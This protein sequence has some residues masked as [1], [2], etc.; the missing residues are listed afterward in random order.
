M[1]SSSPLHPGGSPATC[2]LWKLTNTTGGHNKF[3]TVAINLEKGFSYEVVAFW[4]AIGTTG[5][6]Q[7]KHS[8][9]GTL[10][11]ATT[12][13]RR[14]VDE[15]LSKGYKLISETDKEEAEMKEPEVVPTPEAPEKK[16]YEEKEI[17]LHIN[18]EETGE[19]NEEMKQYIP[20]KEYFLDT[21][22]L[23]AI[24]YGV[25]YNKPT[26]LIGDT[27]C[28]KTAAVR[29]LGNITNNAVRRVNLNGATTVD[30]FVGKW[31][32]DSGNMIW[33]DGVLTECMRKGY[34]LVCDE[35]N[36]VLPEISFVLHSVLDDDQMLVLTQ[37]DGEIIKAHP[38]FRFFATMNP[39]YSGTHRLND[40]FMDRF[41]VVEMDYPKDKEEVDILEKRTT[42]KDR[43]LLSDMVKVAKN[44]RAEFRK[45]KITTSF[46][47]RKLIFW[48]DLCEVFTPAKAF[49][50]AVLNKLPKED[51]QVI[52]DVASV[53]FSDPE[54]R[55]VLEYKD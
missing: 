51:V 50:Y 17:S 40:A 8:G 5:Q 52:K 3:Y 25:K 32:L 20:K 19:I 7:V 37:K 16:T 53:V 42:L 23:K 6:S 45:D 54:F 24:V 44:V 30:E 33:I 39:D 21:G 55:N 1:S 11:A 31:R 46:S 34:W 29:F 27:G 4:G 48:A 18:K 47:T 15:K 10:T 2:H 9:V 12:Y 13:G 14:L 43:K 35:I 36:A 38:N 28:G 22:Y 41:I 49:K 26:L